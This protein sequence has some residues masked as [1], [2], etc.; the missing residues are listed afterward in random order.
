[1]HSRR[2]H[3]AALGQESAAYGADR[4]HSTTARP[5]ARAERLGWVRSRWEAVP[6]P[7]RLRFRDRLR[8]SASGFQSSA[9]VPAQA[10][11]QQC[12]IGSV[13]LDANGVRCR[14]IQWQPHDHGDQQRAGSTAAGCQLAAG[15]LSSAFCLCSMMRQPRSARLPM[16]RGRH[17]GGWVEPH[18]GSQHRLGYY[19]TAVGEDS[20]ALGLN[21]F[22]I[23]FGTSAVGY[24]TIAVGHPCGI[25]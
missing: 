20:M 23:G 7:R 5:W 21:S 16:L 18:N 6:A 11:C 1:M 24:N 14:P 3:P 12:R 19:A 22:A 4:S 8:P 17:S 9:L 25:R 10:T 2:V 15:T 13:A